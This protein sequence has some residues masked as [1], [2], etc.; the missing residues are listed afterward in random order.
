MSVMFVLHNSAD[1][2]ANESESIEEHKA[3]EQLYYT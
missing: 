3:V 1:D 2:F